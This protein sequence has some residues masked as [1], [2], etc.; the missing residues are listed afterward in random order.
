MGYASELVNMMSDQRVWVVEER[1]VPVRL[2]LLV[3]CTISSSSTHEQRAVMDVIADVIKRW[4][5]NLWSDV[6]VY[7]SQMPWVSV[8]DTLCADL[9]GKLC[10]CWGDVA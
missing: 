5:L 9:E 1:L 2:W 8:F 3:L 10:H 7:V 4:Q 6:M